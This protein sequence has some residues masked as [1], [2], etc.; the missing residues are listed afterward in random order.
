MI[1]QLQELLAEQK[2]EKE[3]YDRLVAEY[4][5]RLGLYNGTA[6]LRADC[7]SSGCASGGPKCNPACRNLT[8]LN[9][10][11]IEPTRPIT[12]DLGTFICQICQQSV[13]LGAETDS[14][15]INVA[16]N[17]VAQQ[18]NCI[19]NAETQLATANVAESAESAESTTEVVKPAESTEVAQST[20][21]KKII[22][23]GI[24][25]FVCVIIIAIIIAL[26][27][28]NTSRK[29]PDERMSR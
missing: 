7:A 14:G 29:G 9:P 27:I 4:N 19:A 22:I 18:M 21:S 28:V 12:A 10:R 1:S 26:I 23:I 11:P 25:I 15:D 8:T 24:I 13:S 2:V 16:Q 3:E 17:A 6:Q 5:R 20:G